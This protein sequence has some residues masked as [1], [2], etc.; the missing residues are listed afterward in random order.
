MPEPDDPLADDDIE[1][2]LSPGEETSLSD[3]AKREKWP[4][5]DMVRAKRRGRRDEDLYRWAEYH[6]VGW[7]GPRDQRYRLPVLRRLWRLSH[8]PGVVGRSPPAWLR[9]HID[10]NGRTVWHSFYGGGERTGAR[11][12][13]RVAIVGRAL[14]AVQTWHED[15]ANRAAANE[16]ARA[17]AHAAWVEGK[18]GDADME[19]YRDGADPW[20]EALGRAG[21]TITTRGEAP[22]FF[23]S[24]VAMAIT[25]KVTG[26]SLRRLRQA[27]KAFGERR[28]VT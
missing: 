13:D 17:L 21:S 27:K 24:S 7:G 10:E 1:P 28:A 18:S 16:A 23:A 3:Q 6:V 5:R 19:R 8:H 2:E 12:D 26:V 4:A 9:V 11:G 20:L 25:A 14:E 22:S 15:R